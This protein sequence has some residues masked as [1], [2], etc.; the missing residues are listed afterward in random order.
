M[1]GGDTP[2]QGT[3]APPPST[4]SGSRFG[5]FMTQPVLVVALIALVVSV[6]LAIGSLSGGGGGG[7]SAPT[8]TPPPRGLLAEIAGDYTGQ[9]PFRG[10]HGV[11]QVELTIGLDGRGSLA[12]STPAG[13]CAG[14]LRLR[15]ASSRRT[16]FGYTETEDPASCPHTT[17]VTVRRLGSGELRFNET[18]RGRVLLSGRLQRG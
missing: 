16:V 15:R 5:S 3:Q 8:G 14:E 18:Q 17:T 1:S 11:A 6:P 7:N 13:R 12:R 4:P 10:G 9:A 2:K